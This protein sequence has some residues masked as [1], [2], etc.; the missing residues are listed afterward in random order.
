M[1]L[2][3]L[4]KYLPQDIDAGIISNP[5]NIRYLTGFDTDSGYI[6]VS[7]NG[8]VFMTDS[9]YI[10]AAQATVDCCDVVL[11]K[12]PKELLIKYLK[13]FNCSSFAIEADHVTISG[14]KEF[15]KISKAEGFKVFFDSRLDK[16]I[17]FLRCEKTAEEVENIRAAQAIAEKAFDH[18]VRYIKPGMTE[19]EIA[20]AIDFFMLRNGADG[21]SFDTI[22][23]SGKK[24][25]LPHGVPDEKKIEF[26]DFVTM[27][28]GAVV[29]GCHSDMTRT[30]AVGEVSDMM[31]D[32]YAIVLEAQKAAI[33]AAA[34]G[35][36][37]A[38]VDFAARDYIEKAGYGNAFGH[39]TGHGVGVEIHE[40]PRVSPTS[41]YTLRA[42]NIITV[43]PGIYLPDQFGVR[44][45]DMLHIT[46]TGSENLTSA[47]KE[48]LILNNR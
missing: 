35:V 23:V 30:V 3:N 47:P 15:S 44:I 25:S 29:N 14:Y 4:I 9:R 20:L 28:F 7:R 26:G 39:S 36:P 17:R 11:M 43:E 41:N 12:E 32:V 33:K 38:T 13:K 1:D 5:V 42:G 2:R 24:S 21:I 6:I 22:V 19:K 34:A 16:C 40:E 27:D 18:V 8:S 46:S 37:A 48:L 45:E 10:E 31:A